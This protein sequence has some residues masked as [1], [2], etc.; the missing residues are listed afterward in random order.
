MKYVSTRRAIVIALLFI[1]SP[2]VIATESNPINLSKP[3]SSVAETQ[4][5]NSAEVGTAVV[6]SRDLEA[7]QN[8]DKLTVFFAIGLVINIILMTLF[9]IWAIRQWRK[10]DKRGQANQ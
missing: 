2:V 3:G 6:T 10:S 8:K 4:I 1:I 9:G 7:N 5:S